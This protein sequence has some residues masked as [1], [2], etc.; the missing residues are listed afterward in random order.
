[1]LGVLVVLQGLAGDKLWDS[2]FHQVDQFLPT[3]NYTLHEW[4]G[5]H[6]ELGR[7]V[8]QEDRLILLGIAIV[9]TF[10]LWAF[11]RYT[12]IGLAIS[13]SAE[14]ERAVS[15]LGWSP[16]LLATVTCPIPRPPPPPPALPPPP[17]SP[18]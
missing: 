17:P 12:R 10:V 16:N 1:T 13:A 9:L 15:A 4:F 8:I 3:H 5:F 7:V 2:D 14:N 18:P 11:T 6:G